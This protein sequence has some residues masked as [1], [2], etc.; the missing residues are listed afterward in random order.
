MLRNKE[1]GEEAEEEAATEAG[2]GPKE[3]GPD[4]GTRKSP[5]SHNGEVKDCWR[6]SGTSASPSD[7]EIVSSPLTRNCQR[8]LEPAP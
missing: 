2:V 1:E 7:S 8:A 6:E 5:G 3:T 4:V